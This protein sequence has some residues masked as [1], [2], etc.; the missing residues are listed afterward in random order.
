MLTALSLLIASRN[1][2]EILPYF[3]RLVSLKVQVTMED[4]LKQS[5]FYLIKQGKTLIADQIT[6]MFPQLSGECDTYALQAAST[7]GNLDI[8]NSYFKKMRKV[9]NQ[10]LY[11]YLEALIT[12]GEDR[13]YERAV[14]AASMNYVLLESKTVS[15]LVVAHCKYGHD[16]RAF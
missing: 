9:D 16:D 11:K 12:H 6:T 7:V 4:H 14:E 8:A 15:L 2:K 5:L 10:T 1:T 3:N 13:G